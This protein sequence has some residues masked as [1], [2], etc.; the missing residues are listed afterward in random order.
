MVM[1]GQTTAYLKRHLW[2]RVVFPT[3]IAI[4]MGVA[5]CVM[6]AP[7]SDQWSEHYVA[8]R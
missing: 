7:P 2:N 1:S 5:G 8:S 6:I 3:A 4:I